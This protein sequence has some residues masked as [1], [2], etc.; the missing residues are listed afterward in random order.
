MSPIQLNTVNT[1]PIRIARNDQLIVTYTNGIF[2]NCAPRILVDKSGGISAVTFIQQATSLSQTLIYNS[3]GSSILNNTMSI[4][5]SDCLLRMPT[6]TLPLVFS[7]VFGAAT[8]TVG[9]YDNYMQINAN[10]MPTYYTMNALQVRTVLSD[11][12]IG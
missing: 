11:P 2:S 6:S 4:E 3:N 10:I 5:F 8:G 9:I 1:V 7:L 12:A